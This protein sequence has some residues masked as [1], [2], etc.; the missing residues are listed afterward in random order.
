MNP[1]REYYDPE[2]DARPISPGLVQTQIN[3]VP[4]DTPP[5]Y[6]QTSSSAAS[7]VE[8]EKHKHQGSDEPEHSLGRKKSKK[9]R[10]KK[11][12]ARPF[13]ADEILI[14]CLEPNRPDI[15]QEVARRALN[16][17]SQSE[18]DDEVAKDM[19]EDGD[20]EDEHHATNKNPRHQARVSGLESTAEVALN[21]VS[22]HDPPFEKP[23][24]AASLAIHGPMNGTT[25][26]HSSAHDPATQRLSWKALQGVQSPMRMLHPPLPLNVEPQWT[27]SKA[28]VEDESITTS[29][30]LAKFAISPAKADPESTLP[31][32]QKSPPRSSSSHSPDA[33]H[34]L[35]SLQT[36]LSQY[37]DSP[38]V[39]TSSALSPYPS[40]L[41]HSPS[42]TR[43]QYM[44]G[45][46][47][48][49]PAIYS[50][51]S[52]ASSKDMS[53]MSPPGY[54]AHPTCWRSNPMEGSF[55][56]TSPASV[57]G[58]TPVT[59]SASYPTPKDLP[60]PLEPNPSP[61]PVNGTILP[62]LPF[63]SSVTTT[64]PT[65]TTSNPP[66]AFKCHHPG[67]TAAPFQTQYLLNSHTNVHSSDRPHYCPVKNCSRS[68]G[69]KGFKRKN[70]MIRH[71]LVHNSPG[72]VCPFCADQQHKYPRPDNLQRCVGLD[73]PQ[74]SHH[75]PPF[76]FF[77]LSLS[78]VF[79]SVANFKHRHVRVHHPEKKSDDAQLRAVLELRSGEGGGSRGKARRTR[80]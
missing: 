8:Q 41:G 76:F 58:L 75:H 13:P 43:P 40:T 56:T 21:D 66:S 67:C 47:G 9:K 15:A 37:G 4:E 33:T 48:P 16:S 1:E 50:H 39:E 46:P 5:P 26:K 72:Y 65:T 70:E 77:S 53:I 24:V 25:V 19:S 73:S 27:E 12:R 64:T 78:L 30:A 31:A 14:G 79:W 69:G 29:P 17:A 71:G 62:N 20:D 38:S 3:Y 61:H 54:P 49:S 68:Q 60:L 35:P 55:S 52:P 59:S 34:S 7:E 63:P 51:P 45:N 28:D 44:A 74:P 32:M 11:G 22:M 6:I 23:I 36:A 80:A 18:A 2:E 57:P 10:R 42:V